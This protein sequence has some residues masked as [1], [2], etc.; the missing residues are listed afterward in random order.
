EKKL[1][2]D[3]SVDNPEEFLA[4]KI[5][6]QIYPIN[7]NEIGK[8]TIKTFHLYES[9]LRDQRRNII[10]ITVKFLEFRKSVKKKRDEKSMRAF[11]E[12]LNNLKENKS[13][14]AGVVRFV[15]KQPEDFGL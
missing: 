8:T 7:D 3:P 15:L 9:R 6:G 14:Y 2:I 5:D 13:I 1:L 11:D 12:F 10:S 4:Y